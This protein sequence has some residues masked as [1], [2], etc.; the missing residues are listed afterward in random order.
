MW[1]SLV[2]NAGGLISA[3][4][5]LALPSQLSLSN[6]SSAPGTG[7]AIPL[8][9]TSQGDSISGLQF[10]LEYDSSAMSLSV[11]LGDSARSSFKNLFVADLTPN[12]RRFLIVGFNQ[13]LITDDSLINQFVNLSLNA[14]SG[15]YA[16]KL[17]NPFA[18]DP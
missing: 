13:N 17:S 3:F 5:N 1:K 10:D 15:V 2:L 16:L 7:I 11:S 14:R 18:T 4:T 9:F 8:Q 6:Q 12:K